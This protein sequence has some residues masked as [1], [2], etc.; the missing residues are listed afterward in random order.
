MAKAADFTWGSR[1][2]D[3][4]ARSIEG[5][6]GKAYGLLA[7]VLEDAGGNLADVAQIV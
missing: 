5:L 7:F 1:C 4:G 6:Q 2:K 3:N